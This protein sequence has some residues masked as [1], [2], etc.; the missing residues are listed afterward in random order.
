[1]QPRS[2]LGHDLFRTRTSLIEV[3]LHAANV[4]FV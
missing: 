3:A 4:E 1:M 2:E